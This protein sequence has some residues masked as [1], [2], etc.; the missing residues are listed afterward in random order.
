M[1]LNLGCGNK[2]EVGYVNVDSALNNPDKIWDLNVFPYPWAKNSIDEIRMRHVLEHLD[3]LIAV[4]NEVWTVLKP[5]GRVDIEV[6]Y[7]NHFQAIGHPQ[8]KHFFHWGTFGWLDIIGKDRQGIERYTDKYF[9]VVHNKLVF[10]S[11]LKQFE[12]MFNAYPTVY[13]GSALAKLFPA[14][15]LN[16]LLEKI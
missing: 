3:D 13:N 15:T 1:K 8:H 16:V 10:D 6:P 4:M 2:K 7:V 11:D 9:R 5:K 14:A 12:A